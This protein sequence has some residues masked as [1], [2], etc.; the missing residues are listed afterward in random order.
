MNDK[1]EQQ[2]QDTED[3]KRE[4]DKNKTLNDPGENVIDYGRSEQG[5]VEKTNVEGHLG[6]DSDRKGNESIY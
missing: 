6:D 5:E 2:D 3:I 1:R 4:L